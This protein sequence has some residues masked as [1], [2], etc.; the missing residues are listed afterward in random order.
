MVLFRKLAE[1]LELREG[2]S[3]ANREIEG[4][5]LSPQQERVW[6]LQQ[7]QRDNPYRAQ[8]AVVIEGDLNE[9]LLRKAAHRVVNQHEIL[10]TKFNCFP[11]IGMPLQVISESDVF[12]LPSGDL[13]HLDL[14]QQEAELEAKFQE[15]SRLPFDVQKGPMIQIW[16]GVFSRFKHGLLISLPALCADAVTLNKLVSDIGR[17]CAGDSHDEEQQGYIMQ[18]ADLSE[19]LR[20]LLETED[21]EE[22]R[23]FWRKKDLLSLSSLKLPFEIPLRGQLAF[24]PDTLKISVSAEFAAAI[25]LQAKR[26]G[27]GV[28]EFL[29]TCWLAFLWRLTGRSDVIVGIACDGRSDETLADKLGLLTQYVPVQGNLQAD[30]QFCR[31][32]QQTAK[33]AREA[34]ERQGYFSWRQIARPNGEAVDQ[35]F[36]PFCFQFD[37]EPPKLT[38]GNLAFHI[39]K[40]CAYFDRFKLSLCCAF[41]DGDLKIELSFDSKMY[42]VRDIKRLAE[43]FRV[44]LENAISDP[45][46]PLH[47]LQMLSQGEQR[48]SLVEQRATTIELP[49]KYLHNLFEKQA[50]RIPDAIALVCESKHL[51]YGSLNDHANRLASHLQATGVGPNKSVAIYVER[52]LEMVTGILGILKTGSAYVPLDPAYPKQ[53]LAFILG[54]TKTAVVVTERRMLDQLPDCGVQTLCV[55][56]LPNLGCPANPML[57][58]S[59]DAPAYVIYTSGSTGNPKG[60]LVNH[61]NVIRL[62]SVTQNWFGFNESDIWTLFHSNAFDFSVW[63]IWGALAFG[64]KLIVV[65]Y[66]LSRSP[67][68]FYDLLYA[69]N[70]TVLNQTPSA[71]RQLMRVE[72]TVGQSNLNLRFLIFGGEALDLQSLEPWFY[73]HGDKKPQLINMYGITE[74]TVHV[75]YR[76]ISF[77]D[78]RI[79]AGSVIGCALPDLQI[80]ILDQRGELVPTGIEGEIYV[81]GAGVVTGYL[82]RAELTAQRFVPDSFGGIAGA[83]L[84]RSGDLASSLPNGDI[85]YL[86][87]I[88]DQVKIRGFRIELGE[89][90][91]ALAEYPSVREAIVLVRNRLNGQPNLTHIAAGDDSS[92]DYAQSDKQ[93]VAYVV[94]DQ[95]Q[96]ISIAELRRHVEERLPVYMAPSNYIML[97][98]LPLTVNGKIDRSALPEPEGLRPELDVAFVAP[99]TQVEMELAK[100]WREFLHI[101]QIGIYDNFF[102]LGGHSLLLTQLVSR[103]GDVFHV[104]VS[105]ASVFKNPTIAQMVTV[106]ATKQAQQAAPGEL[107]DILNELKHLS[108][109]EIKALYQ[110]Q[111]S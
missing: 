35:P 98:S 60:V 111:E 43:Q 37:A 72:E 79:S 78:L 25:Q 93:I 27:V 50:E 39:Q 5:R 38:M 26:C 96:P 64:G 16:H 32:F 88:D 13:R 21:G 22:G 4:F 63:E 106:I 71:F 56:E 18:Y 33:S 61:S 92:R 87:R 101:E 103:I 89:I 45:E 28:S 86:G 55:D 34:Y 20:E 11:G 24:E 76:P 70:V 53:R 102:Q 84:Y 47:R 81:G 99:R 40:K 29:L 8:C 6:R 68:P 1:R 108:P 52:S 62:L 48:Q 95:R 90:E 54:D 19:I 107:A 110:Y 51:S 49:S 85:E 73:R 69:E 10:R 36:F 77:S 82:N 94:C 12:W 44:L 30:T 46:L 17:Y 66:L 67:E 57:V 23:A 2:I 14:T 9:E 104:E 59:P 75:T 3:M 15:L 100:I 7:T 42:S 65:P 41:Y 31:A 83:R 74:T 109:D 91:S 97:Q 105:L 80:H 58:E